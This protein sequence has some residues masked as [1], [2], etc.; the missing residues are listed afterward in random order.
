MTARK[1]ETKGI[2][3]TLCKNGFKHVTVNKNSKELNLTKLHLY[4]R[5]LKNR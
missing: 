5:I 3:S 4:P 1:A 2:Y